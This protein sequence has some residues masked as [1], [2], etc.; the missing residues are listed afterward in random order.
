MKSIRIGKAEA[1]LSSVG[2]MNPSNFI[3]SIKIN[4]SKI[5]VLQKFN[6]QK[7]VV[8]LYS[9]NKQKYNLK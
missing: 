7:S 9:S 4:F 3:K 1:K 2:E 5:D 8:L 6:M